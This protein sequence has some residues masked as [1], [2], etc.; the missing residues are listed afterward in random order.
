VMT[1]EGT[2][3]IRFVS[4]DS[5]GWTGESDGLLLDVLRPSVAL[6]SDAIMGQSVSGNLTLSVSAPELPAGLSL[7]STIQLH[8]G[9][10]IPLPSGTGNLVLD[11]TTLPDGPGSAQAMI[12]IEQAGSPEA[13]VLESNLLLFIVENGLPKPPAISGPTAHFV[14]ILN[15]IR[16]AISAADL[17]GTSVTLA[18]QDPAS[19]PTG[20]SFQVDG[21]GAGYAQGALSWTPASNQV[22]AYNLVFA[23]TDGGGLE[24]TLTVFVAAYIPGDVNGDNVV[25]TNDF[26]EIGNHWL[27]TNALR[28]DGDLTGDGIVDMADFIE[29][30]N[31]LGDSY[32]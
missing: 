14:E 10:G 3:Q 12:E 18:L 24:S 9:I 20:A 30:S 29:F 19:L 28:S 2:H 4:T 32:P 5:A 7:T 15:P 6:S 21:D 31:H 8:T 27:E 11:T 23:A 17:N 1:E 16:V 13:V 25:D 26:M 22:G